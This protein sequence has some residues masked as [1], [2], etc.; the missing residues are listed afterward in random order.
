M[1]CHPWSHF[2]FHCPQMRQ[3]QGV[4]FEWSP[5]GAASFDCT[6]LK[7]TK[8]RRHTKAARAESTKPAVFVPLGTVEFLITSKAHGV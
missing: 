3:L 6:R 1:H 7:L 8:R 2:L 5:A 4:S